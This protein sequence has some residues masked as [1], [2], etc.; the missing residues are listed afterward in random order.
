MKQPKVSINI[1]L[2]NGKKYIRACLESVFNQ[3]YQNIEINVLDNNTHLDDWQEVN[4]VKR[5]LC[6][7]S[8][9]C[10]LIKSKK[11]LG[12][13]RGHNFL[14]KHSR[15]KYMLLLNQDCFLA[16]DYLEKTLPIFRRYSKVAAIQGKLLQMKE[17]EGKFEKTGIIDTVGLVI[18]KN[19]RVIAR[20]QGQKDMGQFIQEEEVFGADGAAPIYSHQALEDLKIDGEILDEDFNC[21][22]EDVDLAWRARLFGW[23]T[24]YCP[25]ALAWHART[26]GESAKTGYLGVVKERRK[27]SKFSK[28]VSFRNQ[29]LMQL[30][31]EF[32]PLFLRDF[33]RILFKELAAWFYVLIFER[34]TLKAAGEIFKLAPKAWKKRKIIMK[35][36]RLGW[37]EMEKWFE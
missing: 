19:R 27:I 2:Y 17:R 16:R 37:R 1:L 5:E 22:K 18:F 13:A 4:R 14:I 28:Y 10:H 8:I 7:S 6:P 36:K 21:Y 23:Y 12:F 11:N 20:G 34:Y 9:R 31:N 26:S 3:T 32:W 29:R 24:I 15:G 33:I 35:R 25:K 30:K